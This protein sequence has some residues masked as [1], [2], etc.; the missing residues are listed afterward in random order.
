[1]KVFFTNR[2]KKDWL[3]LDRKVRDQIRAK[4][5]YFISQKNPLRYSEQLKDS[6]FGQFRFRIGDYRI[7]FDVSGDNIFVLRLGHRKDIY[8]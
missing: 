4:L 3:K 2:A 1:M 8:R 7:I 6:Q 5:E